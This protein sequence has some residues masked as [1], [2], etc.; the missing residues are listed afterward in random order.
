M[1]ILPRERAYWPQSPLERI[2]GRGKPLALPPRTRWER[3]V[4]AVRE[5][6]FHA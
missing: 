2:N 1:V 6:L 4:L 3:F 5:W